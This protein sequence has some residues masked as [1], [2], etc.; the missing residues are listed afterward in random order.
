MTPPSDESRLEWALASYLEAFDQG[1]SPDREALLARYPEIREELRSALGDYDLLHR[2][3]EPWR[4][5]A[6]IG[7]LAQPVKV[8]EYD[9][10]ELIDGGGQGL[11]YRA[12]QASLERMVALKMILAGRL[13]TEE[14]L[15]RFRLEA[16][17]AAAMS[18]PNIVPIISFGEHDGAAYFT[19]K[20]IEGKTLA[21][22][23]RDWK[24]D[25]REAVRLVAVVARAIAH[26]HEQKIIHRDL[27]PGNILIDRAGTPW[28]TDFGLAK[29]FVPGEATD[30]ESL[31]GT[32]PYMSPEQFSEKEERLT[33]AVD[34]W[35]LGAILYELLTGKVPFEG[36]DQDDTIHRIRHGDPASM[37]AINLN[38]PRL[39]GDD[40][41]NGFPD[42]SARGAGRAGARFCEGGFPPRETGRV[43]GTQPKKGRGTSRSLKPS[44]RS[45]GELGGEALSGAE[46]NN[47]PGLRTAM[48]E[49]DA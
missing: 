27:K 11:V 44:G 38:V 26:A 2:L 48:M 43:E 22:C 18:H 6:S 37:I 42:Q 9:L 10:L 15:Q 46:P 17:A 30:P 47:E 5:L 39:R 19:M 33:L 16:R 34:I 21:R 12:R 23:D 3:A 36:K 45:G 14:Q 4:Q 20:F 1:K 40:A 8:G 24:S 25:P 35:G 28:V 31:F 29:L 32:L 41:A 7:P 13:A 49:S